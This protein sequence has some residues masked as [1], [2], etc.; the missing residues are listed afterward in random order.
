[1][2]V[3]QHYNQTI[4]DQYNM[5][6]S[7]FIA[8]IDLGTSSIKGVVGR[9]NENNVISILASGAIASKNCI[10]RGTVYNI[11]ETGANVRKLV[12]MLENSLGRKIG[13]VYV[14]LGGQSLRTLEFRETKELLPGG[15][16]TDEIVKQLQASANKYSPELSRAYAVADVE[17]YIDGKPD[18]NPVGVTGTRLDA[19]FK[20]ITGRPNL[21]G[22]IEK[23]ITEKGEI[24]VADYIV[25][26]LAAA[27]VA[28]SD[29]EKELGCAFIDFGAGTTTLS[30]YKGSI[31]RGMVV[32]PFG[33][34]NITR[35]ICA[36]NFTE[37]DAEQLK[38][39]FGKAVES[40]ESSFFSS[41]FSSKPDVDLTQLNRVIAMRLDE[42]T[43]NLKEQ[44]SLSGYE[45]KLGA[46]LIITG[47]ASQLKNMDA[48]LTREF[49]MPVRKAT[50]K[51]TYV[52]N[53][54]ELVNDPVYT[55]V[56][57]ML[58]LGKQDCELQEV[59]VKGYDEFS[60]EFADTG[61]S[62]ASRPKDKRKEAAKAKKQKSSKQG[63]GFFSNVE[64]F[65]GNMFSDDDE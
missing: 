21:M 18:R 50:V 64:D 15:M 65:F 13:K 62:K 11:E 46:G 56:L 5:T 25:G 41:P 26:A 57:G 8:A 10:R 55:K 58:L 42:I 53:F 60:D 30:I 43:A 33:G 52:N 1:M 28:L 22:N 19:S 24:E 61:T 37:A 38:I 16:V 14:S 47:G 31:L 48:Y 6:Q 35:D 54:P 23:S 40:Q 34:K 29:E 2:F 7:G 9:K 63:G 59:E 51:K 49:K 39:K 45:D 36:L 44:I 32:I 17:Y 12:T 4:I 3:K 27:E 20:L